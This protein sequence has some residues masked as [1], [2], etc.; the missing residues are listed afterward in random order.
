MTPSR[1]TFFEGQMKGLL[2]IKPYELKIA[3]YSLRLELLL[4]SLQPSYN[5]VQPELM[6]KLEEMQQELSM[7][8]KHQ[9]LLGFTLH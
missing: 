6:G 3:H 7:P 9:I 1:V 8:I 2:C 4:T 5:F